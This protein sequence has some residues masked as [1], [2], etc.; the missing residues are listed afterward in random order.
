MAALLVAFDVYHQVDALVEAH[1]HDVAHEELERFE[2]FAPAP[3]Q[4]S[5]VFAFEVEHGAVELFAAR[6]AYGQSDVHV[7]A[8]DEGFYRLGGEARDV[9]RR[10]AVF[11]E[12]DADDGG[13]G[14]YAQDAG[15]AGANDVY[16]DVAAVGV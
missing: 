13:L 6:L 7:H 5:G 2:R 3:Y 9:G 12:R 8:A 10:G 1:A 4:Q 14:A 11:G 15:F 16:F